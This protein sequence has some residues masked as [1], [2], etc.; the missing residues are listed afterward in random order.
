MARRN[1]VDFGV[2][3]LYV[4]RRVRKIAAWSSTRLVQRV[5]G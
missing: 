4:H 1:P 5:E 2:L 3:I